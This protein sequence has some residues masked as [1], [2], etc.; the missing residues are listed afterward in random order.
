MDGAGGGGGG[1]TGAAPQRPNPGDLGLE[2]VLLGILEQ[3]GAEALALP[4]RRNREAREQHDRNRVTREPLLQAFGRT[5]I[6]YLADHQRVVP[7]DF[8]IRHCDL[9]L[10]GLGLLVL[11][12]VTTVEPV[13]AVVSPQVF[14][15]ESH[16]NAATLEH[17]RLL[18]QLRKLRRRA[19][20]RR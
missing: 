10:R 18:E 6:L 3:A 19:G 5:V 17:T 15:P 13:G 20:R 4:R 1:L 2:R 8:R 12:R 7:G 9:G 11:K 14:D 16:L